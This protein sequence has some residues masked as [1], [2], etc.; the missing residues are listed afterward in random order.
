M[1]SKTS[2]LALSLA[3]VLCLALAEAAF[4][5][6]NV[7]MLMTD[8]QT[9]ADMAAMPQTKR[10]VGGGGVT[11][12]NSYVS[13]PVCCP[14]RATYLTGQYAH[15]H[16]VMGLYPPTGGYGRFD[17]RENLPVWLQRAGYTTAHV[18][19][20]LNGYGKPSPADVPRGWSEW[21]GAVG[22]ST[23]RM[24]GFKLNE[25][26]I[27]RRYGAGDGAYQT[28]VVRDKAVD[29]IDRR[30]PSE[31]PFFLSVGFLAPHHEKDPLLASTG[32]ALRPAPRHDGRFANLRL[33]R[34]PGFDERDTSDKPGFIRRLPRLTFGQLARLERNF[35]ARRESLLA[36]DEAVQGVV[37]ALRRSGELE[38]T[39]IVFTSDNGFMAGEHRV[40]SG[41]MLA[42]KA[43]TQVPLLLR[44]PGVPAGR[45]S[46]ELV[47]NVDLA[48]TILKLA[49]ARSTKTLDGRSLMPF[50]RRP[51]R[52]TRRPL[53]HETGGRRY[54][55]RENLD[56]DPILSTR[57]IRTYRAV[58]TSRYLY[59][60]YRSGGE[61]L[62]DLAR[63]PNELRSQHANPRYGAVRMALRHT[64]RRLAR[65]EGRA[66]RKPQRALPRPGR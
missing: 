63:D 19:K 49:R 45:T 37:A 2:A 4:A 57:R 48:P 24:W 15:N 27:I 50:A 18:G 14:S 22:A 55:S 56:E 38:N 64:L 47:G 29:F 16:G 32:R 43:S 9:V 13:Y 42:Y 23:Y 21:Y 10:L 39:L 25:N 53:L 1:L 5:R 36:V 28:D 7:V 41:K 61:E 62:Y 35:Q 40:P 11:F 31:D 44:G 59:V 65:C 8:D 6:P 34:P 12:R 30:A 20:Y 52:R 33:P 26:G 66:C 54:V 17:K 46:R 60:N 51:E 58:R 3:C